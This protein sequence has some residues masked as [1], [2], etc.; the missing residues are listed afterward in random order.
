MLF[1]PWADGEAQDVVAQPGEALRVAVED[2][3]EDGHGEEP[4]GEGVE[5]KPGVDQEEEAE[6]GEGQGLPGLDEPPG[7]VAVLGPGV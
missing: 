5:V 4:G 6:E 1:T 2:E 3:E 7:Q